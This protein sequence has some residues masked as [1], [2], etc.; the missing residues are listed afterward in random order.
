MPDLLIFGLVIALAAFLGAWLSFLR[1]PLILAYIVTGIIVGPFLFKDG[2]GN[3]FNLLRDLGLSFLLF[4]VGL[5]IRLDNL[6][7]FGAQALKT[8]LTQIVV[9]TVLAILLG[10]ALGYTLFAN[11]FLGLALAFS[12]T[13]IVVKLLTEKR[14]FDSLYGRLSISIL[15]LQDLLAIVVLIL[16][17]LNQ[18]DASQSWFTSI[19]NIFIG[20]VILGVVY[21]LHKNVLPYLFDRLARNIELLFLSSLAWL[22]LIT[23]ALGSIGFSLEIGAFVAGLGLASLKSEHQIAARVRPLRDLFV[24]IFFIILGSHVIS[25]FN[26]Q[27]LFNA[28]VFSSFVLLIKPLVLLFALGRE[29]FARRTSFMVGISLAQISEFSLVLLFLGLSNGILSEEAVASVTLASVIT[30]AVSSYWLVFAN[31]IYRRVDKYLKVFESKSLVLEKRETTDLS[32]H[33][34]LIGCNRLGWEI[35]KQIQKQSGQILVVDFNPGVVKS[36]EAAQVENIFGD[37]SDPDIFEA[38]GIKKSSLVIST[39]FD[40]GDTKQLLEETSHLEIKPTVFVTAA[41]R[42]DAVEFYRL[43]AD[44]VIVPR[45]LSGHQVAHLL[46]DEKLAEIRQGKMKA[47]HLQELRDG[48]EKIGL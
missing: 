41:V 47:D 28:L 48:L 16:L 36:L 10:L 12:S 14:D 29:G 9:T 33:I 46:T 13:V 44:Y 35:L 25:S 3:T 6:K 43:G 23:A 8:G 24:V 42:E 5:E 19:A 40:S 31:K 1:L 38:A 34:V 39:V 20:L 18:K 15:L 32:G 30:I 22:F 7:Q 17:S 27:I 11:L 37:V 2:S 21:W 4:L 45:I 26:L